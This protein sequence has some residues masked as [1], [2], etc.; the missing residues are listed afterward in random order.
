MKF[1]ALT[2]YASWASAAILSVP[3]STTDDSP[4]E[5]S[6][7]SA[8]SNHHSALHNA[9][10]V[11]NAIHGAMRQWDSTWNHNGMSFMLATVPKDT[12][13][14]HGRS[15]NES[16][17]GMEWLAFEPEHALGFAHPRGR[18]PPGGGPPHMR[19][20]RKDHKEEGRR[21][22]SHDGADVDSYTRDK[23]SHKK[24]KKFSLKQWFNGGKDS[25][26]HSRRRPHDSEHD[27]RP[28]KPGHEDH[29]EHDKR[30]PHRSEDHPGPRKHGREDHKENDRSDRHHDKHDEH[31]RPRPQ[32]SDNGG[33]RKHDRED[34]RGHDGS[35]RHQGGH[36]EHDRPGPHHFE[37]GDRPRKPC[38]KNHERD[39]ERDHES[40]E[41]QRQHLERPLSPSVPP[42][43]HNDQDV[44]APPEDKPDDSNK[45]G[46]LHFYRTKHELNLL[47]IDGM[48]AGKTT[49][50][51]MDSQDYILRSMNTTESPDRGR[52]FG[53]YERGAQ[54][55]NMTRD[56]W[57]N[58][59]DGFIRMEQGFEI[60]LCK[61]ED[62][63]AFE[64]AQEVKSDGERGRGM[65]GGGFAMY[66]AVSDRFHGIGGGRVNV[67]YESMV[68]A[69]TYKSLDGLFVDSPAVEGEKLP[70]LAG[71]DE[72][73]LKEIKD[74]VT[75]M[76]LSTTSKTDV[77]WQAVAEMF[78]Q[79]YAA[80]LQYLVSRHLSPKAIK[81]ELE[82][83]LKPF[84][85]DETTDIEL[86][87]TRCIEQVLPGNQWNSSL[88]GRAV[89][90]VGYHVCITLVS[91]LFDLKK[92]KDDKTKSELQGLV[93]W[94][95][96]PIWRECPSG[97]AYD[98]RC[99]L[100]L[101]PL[102]NSIEFRKQPQCKNAT[103]FEAI[104]GIGPPGRNKKDSYW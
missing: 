67:D 61:F 87:S 7:A 16:V 60:I 2:S 50:G 34:H 21:H 73:V 47:L 88:A 24:D 28:R 58:K 5:S 3:T 49:I 15:T 51:T 92:H 95:D 104:R 1:L 62:H 98:E 42:S 39:H 9:N 23:P 44:L 37:D 72:I 75:K 55:C 69:F 93:E 76:V 13:F 29:D 81:T 20:E 41:H 65:R 90:Q 57:D 59:I 84:T 70:R 82:A 33:P 79:R 25:E 45:S 85:T 77:N 54:L 74:D 26:E 52:A 83:L 91:A 30:Q 18:G 17:T 71:Q 53:D 12:Q 46:Y 103:G 101:W 36:E 4:L 31:A 10:H 96:W 38:D 11:F 6:T 40:S 68:S 86:V 22:T 97:C 78:V 43:S 80:P 63:L 27:D 32:R 48:S 35:E 94:L 56:D 19:H 100:P 89:K 64:R 102:V 99:V 66:K 8:A 14:Y